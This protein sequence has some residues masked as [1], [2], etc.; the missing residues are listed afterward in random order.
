M[1]ANLT[2]AAAPWPTSSTLFVGEGGWPIS[3]P[4]VYPYPVD[5]VTIPKETQEEIRKQLKG[6]VVKPAEALRFNSGKPDWSLFPFEAAEEIVK[7]LEF[8]A[9]KYA[10]WNFTV[11][12]GLSWKDCCSSI[13]R[14]T[15]A[16]LR[17]EDNDPES[18]LSHIA[19]VGCNVLFL[20]TYIRNRKEFTKDDR[21]KRV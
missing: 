12:G 14:H 4:N 21:I 11:N 9:K 18:G 10:A 6:M 17:G 19:H 3:N 8:G 15:F 5:N 20:L 13:L 7:V 16:F 2:A 1:S